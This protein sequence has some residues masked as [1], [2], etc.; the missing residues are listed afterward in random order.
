MNKIDLND[1]EKKHDYDRLELSLE[2]QKLGS[3]CP[4]TPT[5]KI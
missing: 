5:V 1:E 2:I 3:T 4:V